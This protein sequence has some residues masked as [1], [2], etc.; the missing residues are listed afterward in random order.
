MIG[1]G[2]RV[3]APLPTPIVT[4]PDRLAQLAV[5][6]AL[7][8]GRREDDAVACW[9]AWGPGAS[10]V[11]QGAR[12]VAVRWSH[13][14]AVAVGA[15]HV[16]A[17]DEAGGVRCWGRNNAGELGTG[18]ASSSSAPLPIGFAP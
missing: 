14:C 15:Y 13:A 10:L 18:R 8:C 3:D 17:R 12:D 9:H 4:I 11:L 2:S 1:T 5:G 7:M 6:D 16:C